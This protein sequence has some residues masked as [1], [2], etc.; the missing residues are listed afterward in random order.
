MPISIRL[1]ENQI[2][3]DTEFVRRLTQDG[4]I[5]LKP[6]A[7]DDR[8]RCAETETK[9]CLHRKGNEWHEKAVGKG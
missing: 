4:K 8:F 2:T 9:V 5:I 7:D 6:F 3:L 1:P